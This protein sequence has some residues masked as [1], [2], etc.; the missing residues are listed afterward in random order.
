MGMRCAP[1]LTDTPVQR[2]AL[3]VYVRPLPSATAKNSTIPSTAVK[4]ESRSS[5]NK[6]TSLGAAVMPALHIGRHWRGASEF[7]RCAVA[8]VP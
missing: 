6:I 3:C 8:G 1:Y 2:L 7:T 5:P 4:A